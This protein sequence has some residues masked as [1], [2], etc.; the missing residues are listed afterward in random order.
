MAASFHPDRIAR[1]TSYLTLALAFQKVLSFAYFVYI[2]RAVGHE[3]IG[4]Y[5]FALSLTTIFG[6]FIDIGLSPILTREIAKDREKTH[7]FLNTAT[8]LKILTA[9]FA[10]GAV[11]AIINILDYPELTRHLV[12]IAG[13]I[14]ILDSFTLSFYAVFRGYQLLKYESTGVILNK[15]VVIGV[16]ASA[17]LAGKGVTWL[18]LAIFAGSFFNVLY[19]LVLLLWKVRW[20]PRWHL[21]FT[22]LRALLRLAL[23]FAIAS[24]F[25]TVFGYVD[26]VLLNILGGERGDSYT[27]WYGTAYKLTYAF[28]FIPIAVAAA[29]FPAMS[30][31]FVSSKELLARTFDRAMY[32]LLIISVPI[33]FGV[34]A[35]ADKLIM[36]IWG[37]AF[38][39]SILPLQILIVSLVFLFANYPVGSLLNACN[40]Q[41]RNTVN[42][43]VT[44]VVSVVLNL[45]LIPKYT[46][47]GT[48]IASL[49]SI[50]VMFALG[51]YVV[52]Q[53]IRYDKK[54]LVKTLAKTLISAVIMFAI[55]LL[56]KGALSLF[57]LIPVGV[58]VYFLL[59]FLLRG[60]GQREYMRIY[61]AIMNRL[62]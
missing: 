22:V 29:V 58:V 17:L 55:M 48:S 50:I 25:I 5:L 53:I 19:T 36:T 15:I 61:R 1:N 60:F 47:I 23:P 37:E 32:Y 3:D 54:F 62:S 9:I 16:G 57:L 39:A 31:Y 52:G 11:F 35:I 12:Y 27:G 44:M 18:V 21:N 13:F 6:I 38:E 24:I 56:L 26:T 41:T 45:A 49:I 14:M 59:L 4:K 43:G 2:S 20:R 46:F 42:I 7:I 34:I 40:R 10:Y 28:Q 33:A 51:F 8:T 30:S